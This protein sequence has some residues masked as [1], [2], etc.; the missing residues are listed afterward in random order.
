V[1]DGAFTSH[2]TR[3]FRRRSRVEFQAKWLH[4]CE[5][6][7]KGSRVWRKNGV[8]HI[9]RMDVAVNSSA[10]ASSPA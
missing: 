2:Y 1:R 9:D 8:L 3:S 4:L 6:V 7:L 10:R 5:P